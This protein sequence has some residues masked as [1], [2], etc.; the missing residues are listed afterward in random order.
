[1]SPNKNIVAAILFFLVGFF[2]KAEST[3]FWSSDSYVGDLS[4]YLNHSNWKQL[5]LDT[6]S[7]K[8]WFVGQTYESFVTPLL[9]NEHDMIFGIVSPQ[10]LGELAS[11]KK[12]ENLDSYFEKMDKQKKE[13]FLS[14]IFPAYLNSYMKY[15]N[16]IYGLPIDGDALVLHYRPSYFKDTNLRK[17]FKLKYK[18]ELK[19]PETW[20]EYDQTAE[21]FTENLKSK[22]VYGNYLFNIDP[23]V[24]TF[25]YARLAPLQLE[26]FDENMSP[27][28]N[29]EIVKK[30]LR[31]YLKLARFSHPG[32]EDLSGGA[33]VKEWSKKQ[34]VMTIWWSDLSELSSSLNKDSAEDIAVAPLPGVKNKFGKIIR[35]GQ[36]PYGR[37]IVIPSYLD[38]KTKNTVF[39]ELFELVSSP[40]AIDFLAN[41]KTGL[42]PYLISQFDDKKS[43]L[44]SSIKNKSNLNTMECVDNLLNVSKEEIKNA[45]PQPNWPGSYRYFNFLGRSIRQILMKETDVETAVTNIESEWKKIRNELGEKEQIKHWQNYRQ[46]LLNTVEKK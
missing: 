34:I 5:N 45:I 40:K 39:N 38:E 42:D 4:I 28:I 44:Q 21:F 6:K 10:F 30:T 17:K 22:G 41:P 1:M 9:L 31:D 8:T 20:E 43:Y 25:W 24:W 23:W 37:V 3:K 35:H 33:A 12:I 27:L 19:V 2:A 18:K 13:K 15:E 32:V 14:D 46:L 7:Q 16:S 11:N 29:N 26:L 36:I